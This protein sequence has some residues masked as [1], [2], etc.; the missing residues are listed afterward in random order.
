MHRAFRSPCLPVALI[1]AATLV[2]PAPA[3]SQRRIVIA[4]Q[5]LDRALLALA[6]QSG[7]NILFAPDS[8]TGM[9]ARPVDAADFDGAL[10]QMLAGLPV[11]VVRQTAGVSIARAARRPVFRRRPERR[12]AAPPPSNAP[13]EATIY[14]TGIRPLQAPEP[15]LPRAAVPDA[16][17]LSGDRPSPV[18]RNLAEALARMPGVLTRTTNLQGDLGGID[19]AARADGQFTAIRGLS[20]AYSLVTIDGVAMPQALPYGRDAQMGLLPAF[21]FGAVRL[22]KTPGPE[23]A[24]DATGAVIDVQT[25]SAFDPGAPVLKLVA[26]GGIDGSALGYHQ[27]AGYGQI[28]LRAARRFDDD[29]WGVAFGV[30]AG[31][32]AFANSQQTYQQGSIEFRQVT[33]TGRTP[34]GLDPAANLLLASVNAQFTRGESRSAS[35]MAALDFKPSP[36][37]HLYARLS[38]AESATDQDIY[39]LGFQGGG[40]AADITRTARGDGT[41][42]LA[43]TRGA[44]H[45][46]YQTNPERTHFALAQIGTVAQIGTSEVRARAH[47]GIG[48][49][50]RPDHI[51]TSYWDSIGTALP[52]GVQLADRGGYPVPQLSAADAALA[53]RVLDYPV[54]RFAQKRDQRSDDRRLGG[55]LALTRRFGEAP[56]DR[57]ELGLGIDRSRRSNRQVDVDYGLGRDGETLA[58]SGLVQGD[59]AAILP[60]VYAYRLPLIDGSR[61]RARIGAATPPPL[62]PDILNGSSLDTTETIA[63]GYTRLVAS[64]GPVTIT[65]GLRGEHALLQT[66]YW[67]SGN[68]G[69]PAN[70]IGYGW[71]RSRSRFTA[72][73]PG[74]DLRWR[75]GLRATLWTSYTRPSPAQL[76]GSAT[77]ETTDTGALRITRGNPDLRA[78]RAINLDVGQEWRGRRGTT[79]SL[80]AFAKRLTHYLYD[81]GGDYAN[82]QGAAG[83]AGITVIQPRN[84]GTAHLLG[85]EASGVLPLAPGLTLAA[86]ATLLRGRV[87]LRH[88]DLAAIEHLQYA[89]DY[90]LSAELR[91][92][93]GGWEATLL[94]RWTGAYVQQYGL[95]GTSSSGYSV[96]ASSALDQWV[97]PARQVDASLA[98]AIG[99]RANLRLFARNLLADAAYR[100]TIGRHSDTVPQT[101]STGRLI[102]LAIDWRR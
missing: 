45:Y 80:T 22:I 98:H 99:G 58:A 3:W 77:V 37:L 59:I 87:R 57:L 100:S 67:L 68:S 49:V 27:P 92:R 60:G 56:F 36:A 26:I 48:V 86:Q 14:V 83:D 84:G 91:Y 96:L 1:A 8:V 88:P 21:G 52:G 34:T 62:T 73:L 44:L 40:S 2:A 15:G 35:G 55:A 24:G 16:D 90:N 39:Q 33:A 64:V 41:Y 29:R 50:S 5:P 43:S 74:L 25:P 54:H 17:V 71:N 7:R 46:W 93:R 79:L 70:G 28:G 97:R 61:L 18:D 9:V 13:A 78:V 6:R 89:P 38:A 65:A 12:A 10:A 30:Q 82:A 95:L 23:R 32:R 47:W 19:R 76:A 42:N 20:G 51:E 53:A 81:A 85:L 66:D 69:V 11:R 31:R 101:V 4:A 75:S 102:G 72:L 94:G 63:T